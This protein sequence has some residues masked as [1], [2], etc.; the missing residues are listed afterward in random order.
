VR[1]GNYRPTFKIFFWMLVVDV[2][3]LGYVGGKP[4]SSPM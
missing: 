3:I 1:S 4:A 2:L